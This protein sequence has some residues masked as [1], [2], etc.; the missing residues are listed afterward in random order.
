M[1]ISINMWMFLSSESVN[2]DTA[3]RRKTLLSSCYD[4]HDAANEGHCAGLIYLS[5]T[6]SICPTFFWT[7]P[8]SFSFWPLAVR[9]ELLV[10]WPAFSSTVPFASCRLPLISFF[11]LWCIWFLL[12]AFDLVHFSKRLCKK[13]PSRSGRRDSPDSRSASVASKPGKRQKPWAALHSQA[14]TLTR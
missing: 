2:P 11:V 14:G 3:A 9:L 4:E 6:A 1:I 7:L 10:T 13:S 12:I 8:A 5:N